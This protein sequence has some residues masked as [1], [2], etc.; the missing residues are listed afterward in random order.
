MPHESTKFAFSMLS[1]RRKAR[2]SHTIDHIDNITA[3]FVIQVTHPLPTCEHR[4]GVNQ[5]LVI[6]YQSCLLLALEFQ[7][8]SIIRAFDFNDEGIAS[9]GFDKDLHVFQRL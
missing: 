8:I 5:L 3:Y 2:R 4:I 9:N 7:S 1:M 6:W